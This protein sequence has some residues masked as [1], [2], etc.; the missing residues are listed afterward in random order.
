MRQ[1]GGV[2]FEEGPLTSGP[3]ASACTFDTVQ[4]QGTEGEYIREEDSMWSRCEIIRHSNSELVATTKYWIKGQD[5]IALPYVTVPD[6]VPKMVQC[7][8]RGKYKPQVRM[9]PV[10]Q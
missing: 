6:A 7:N 8:D 1:A 5:W 4:Y 3:S 2:Y 10:E 9:E